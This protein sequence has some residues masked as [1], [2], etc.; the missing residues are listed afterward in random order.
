MEPSMKGARASADADGL[1]APPSMQSGWT[2][3]RLFDLLNDLGRLRVISVCGPSVFEAICQA[4]P[5]EIVGGSLNMITDAYHWHFALKRLGHLRSFDTTHARSGRRV[6]FFEL[7][8]R[9]D[10]APFLRIY[11]YRGTNEDFD[12]AVL[13]RFAE[14]HRELAAGVALDPWEAA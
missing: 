8:E 4:G 9:E 2:A 14:A 1:V 3:T 10:D 12:P 5:Y 11:A 7:R 13:E 6:L